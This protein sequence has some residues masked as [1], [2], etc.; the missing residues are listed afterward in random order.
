[1]GGT[2]LEA[3]LK[4]EIEKRDALNVIQGLTRGRRLW[5]GESK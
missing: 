1:L 3:L 5:G 4:N 2:G